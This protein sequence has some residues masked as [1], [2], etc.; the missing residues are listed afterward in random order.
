LIS[1]G[2]ALVGSSMPSYRHHLYDI[3]INCD[4]E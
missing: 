2:Y 1:E 3:D 4:I